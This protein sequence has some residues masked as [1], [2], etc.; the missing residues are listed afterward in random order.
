MLGMLFLCK[1]NK[2]EIKKGT[3][4]KKK[5]PLPLKILLCSR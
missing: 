3:F 5:A 4:S 1:I 2:K